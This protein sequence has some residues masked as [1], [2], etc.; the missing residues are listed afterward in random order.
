MN[1]MILN[2]P[3]NRLPSEI[4]RIEDGSGK[5]NLFGTA[6]QANLGAGQ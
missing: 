2:P 6:S 5:V 4:N 1:S 3:A